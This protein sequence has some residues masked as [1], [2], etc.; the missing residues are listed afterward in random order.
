MQF[1]IKKKFY[2]YQQKHLEK[3]DLLDF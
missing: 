2:P 1:V 3:F